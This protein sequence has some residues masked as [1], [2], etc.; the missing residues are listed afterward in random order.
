MVATLPLAPG[1]LR[2][3]PTVALRPSMPF[4]WSN[5]L[6]RSKAFFHS[7]SDLSV[8][9][10]PGSMRQ[11]RSGQTAMKSMSATQ[12]AVFPHRLVH[13]EYLLDQHD[14]AGGLVLRFQAIG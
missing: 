4:T 14:D 11:N 13:T 5:L 1:S 8:M 9:S 2:A 3:T 10:T 12:A 7:A 6:N